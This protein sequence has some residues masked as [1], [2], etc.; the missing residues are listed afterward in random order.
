MI[1]SRRRF[2]ESRRHEGSGGRPGPQRGT[3][4]EPRWGPRG[5]SPR[6]Q[7]EFEAFTLVKCASPQSNSH[8]VKFK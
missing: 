4:A 2:F 5:R 6:E 1:L 7:N 3:G 8:K